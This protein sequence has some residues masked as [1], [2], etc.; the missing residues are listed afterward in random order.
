MADVVCARCHKYNMCFYRKNTFYKTCNECSAKLSKKKTY[1]DDE[2]LYQQ[3]YHINN[4]KKFLI[5]TERK[6]DVI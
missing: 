3:L 4:S 6:S 5:R 2:R 1:T